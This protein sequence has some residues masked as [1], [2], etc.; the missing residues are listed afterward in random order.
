MKLFFQFFVGKLFSGWAAIISDNLAGADEHPFIYNQT[1]KADRAAS[2][3]FVCAYSDFCAK[4][5]TVAIAE[6]RAA[7]P[8]YAC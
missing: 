7:I 5:I 4:T 2:V 6:T 3:N 1:F 8:E